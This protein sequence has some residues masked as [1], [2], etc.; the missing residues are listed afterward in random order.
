MTSDYVIIKC[1]KI[2]VKKLDKKKIVLILGSRLI[3]YVGMYIVKK[4]V[5]QAILHAMCA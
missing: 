3:N 4:L 5:P 1:D 2:L